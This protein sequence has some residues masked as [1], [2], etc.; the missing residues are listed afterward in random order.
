MI[1]LFGQAA[2]MIRVNAHMMSVLAM[3]VI[4][5]VV[6]LF[7]EWKLF[8]FDPSFGK[9]ARNVTQSNECHLYVRSSADDRDGDSGC[10]G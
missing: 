2:T 5:V 8:L 7:K 6:V 1:T 10:R 9:R 4:L 3:I